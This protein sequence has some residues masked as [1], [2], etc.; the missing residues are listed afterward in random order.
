MFRSAAFV[1]VCIAVAG[2]VE[3]VKSPILFS[4]FAVC[5]LC[6]ERSLRH[7]ERERQIRYAS[8]GVFMSGKGGGEGGG[9]GD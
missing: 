4:K 1:V 5:A 9:A 2:C 3:D 6:H 8:Q 7:T